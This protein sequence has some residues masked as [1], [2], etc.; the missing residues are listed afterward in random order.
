[1]MVRDVAL[2]QASQA[3]ADTCPTGHASRSDR[4][5]AGENMAGRGGSS[6]HYDVQLSYLDAI[7]M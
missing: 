6:Y 7:N 5:G 4:D 1:M 3:Y 2:E